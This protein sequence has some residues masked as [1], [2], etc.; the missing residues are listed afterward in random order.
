MNLKEILSLFRHG[1]TTARSHI[2]NLIAIA[3]A[4]GHLDLIEFNLLQKIAFRNNVSEKELRAIHENPDAV[5]FDL[6]ETK[7]ERLEQLFDL[8]HM[9]SVDK[10]IHPEEMRL[11]ELFAAKL[12]IPRHR[13]EE[14]ISHIQVA[15]GSGRNREE[16]VSQLSWMLR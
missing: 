4:D 3:M 13:I 12:Q 9:M 6:P 1:Q 5:V 15:I 11:C 2:K 8:V 10:S 14:A 7:L 16:V